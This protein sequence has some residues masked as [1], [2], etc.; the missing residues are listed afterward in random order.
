MI[1]SNKQYPCRPRRL[2]TIFTNRDRPLFFVT[3]CTKDR[4]KLLDKISVHN[5]FI[6]YSTQ[7]SATCDAWVGKYV[8]MPD[9]IHVFISCDGSSCLSRWVKG[10][11][12]VLSKFFRDSGHKGPFWQDGFFDHL[13]RSGESYSEKWLYVSHNPVRAGLVNKPED[14]VFSGEI[15]ILMWN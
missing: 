11:K 8:I 13:L 9:H 10:L 4:R 15:E 7:S 1:K 2:T 6:Q 14:W 3:I 12:G 5:N